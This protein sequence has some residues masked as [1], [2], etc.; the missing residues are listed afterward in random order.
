MIMGRWYNI[1]GLG[2]RQGERICNWS[3]DE[4]SGVGT[5][6][7]RDEWTIETKTKVILI[8]LKGSEAVEMDGRS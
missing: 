7:G 2:I 8:V 1:K 3:M 6:E 5:V 4:A